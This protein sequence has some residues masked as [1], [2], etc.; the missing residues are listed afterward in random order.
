MSTTSDAAKANQIFQSSVVTKFT[1][2]AYNTLRRYMETMP[3]MKN[4]I[5]LQLRAQ[6]FT[7]AGVT[8][9]RKAVTNSGDF[10]E[11]ISILA[12]RFKQV[13]MSHKLPASAQHF[14][15]RYSFFFVLQE[16][17]KVFAMGKETNFYKTCTDD[18]LELLKDQEVLR[19]KYGAAEVAPESSSV[20]A[21]INS[22][23][24]Y[25]AMNEREQ[26]RL[27]T[28]ALAYQDPCLFRNWTVEQSE[29]TCRLK[30]QTSHRFQ[31]IRTSRDSWWPK[32]FRSLE[33]H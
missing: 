8:V 16:A 9:A 6:K 1:P 21:T 28:D 22:I 25:A 14:V 29:K 30:S 11:K 3:D 17:S 20:T 2:E 7:G 31:A 13:R 10:R 18:Y 15:F 12:V 24:R 33:V 23:L 19:T 4:V 27:L 5:N 32:F 26:N